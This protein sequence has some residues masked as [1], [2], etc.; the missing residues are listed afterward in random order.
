MWW[1]NFLQTQIDLSN[2]HY[3][4]SLSWKDYYIHPS[5]HSESGNLKAL[6]QSIDE[7]NWRLAQIIHVND[8]KHITFF[9]KFYK[10]F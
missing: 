4:I 5:Y 8:E 10:L 1:F 9:R 7:F 6:S 2:N 3:L